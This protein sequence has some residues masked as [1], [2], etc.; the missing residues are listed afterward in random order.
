MREFALPR[1]MSFHIIGNTFATLMRTLA[2]LITTA[3]VIRIIPDALAEDCLNHE[4][5]ATQL[6]VTE[7]RAMKGKDGHAW[8]SPEQPSSPPTL[9][10]SN[11]LSSIRNSYREY[12]VS[13][14]PVTSN[15]PVLDHLSCISEQSAV[16]L[17]EIQ[18]SRQGNW[19]AV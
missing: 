4:S 5:L 2:E 12:R 19:K 15:G 10:I 3:L 13:T 18:L 7:M 17:N 14:L 9:Y 1:C 8:G 16:F 6:R 11:Y